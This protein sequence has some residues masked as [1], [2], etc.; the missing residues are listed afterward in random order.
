METLWQDIRF[1]FRILFKS[2]A[3]TLVAALTL[4]LGIGVNTAI[5]SVVNAVLLRPLPGYETGRLVIIWGKTPYSDNDEVTGDAFKEWR[6]QAQSFEQIEAGVFIPCSVTGADAREPAEAVESVIVT[7]GYFSLYRAQAAMGRLFLPGEDSAGRDH[8]VVLDHDYWRRRFSGDPAIVGKTIHLN[9]EEYVVVG[10]TPADFHPLGRGRA[11]FYLPLAFDKYSRTVFWVVARLKAGV[12]FEQA[13][14]EMAVISRR[15]QASDPKNYENFEANPVPILETWVAQIRSVLLLL[16]GGVAVVLLIACANVANLLLARGAARRQEFAI[17]L[18]LGASRF[19]L[20]RQMAVESLLL[21]IGGGGIGLSLA[22]GVVS[23]LGKAKWLS[24]PRLDEISIDWSVL[25][26][27]FLAVI[28]TGLLCSAGPALVITRQDVSR[29]LETGARGFAGSRAQNRA[30]QALIV[31][32]IA[33]TFTLLYVAGLLTQSFARMQRVNLGYDPRNVLTFSI[34]LP[35]TTDPDGRQFIATYDRI[36]ER[37]RRLPGVENVGLTT[38]LPT[39][40]GAGAGGDIR[41]EGRPEPSHNNDANATLRVVSADY[42]RVLHIPLLAG[43]LFDERDTIGRPNVTIINQSVARRFFPDSSPL[44]QRLLDSWLDPNIRGGDDRVI[45]REI[46]GLVGDVKQTSVTDE[47]KMETIAPYS[48]NGLRFTMIA[49]RTTGDPMKLSGA[50]RQ[51]VAQEDKDLPIADVKTMEER[52]ST[53]TAQSRTSVMIFGVFAAL[54]L[55]LAAIGIYGVMA[56]AVT[57]RTREI[58]VRMALGAR[59]WDVRSLI[60]RQGF[61]ITLIGLAGGSCAVFAVAQLL[62]KFLFGVKAADPGALIGV[63]LLLAMAALAACYI[64][65]RRATNVDPMVALRHE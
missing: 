15:L 4:A 13:K 59:G 37:L 55:T 9:R 51:A 52:A 5:F 56:Y 7:P 14:A 44:G 21:A 23:A 29:G 63:A 45:A 11:P 28:I 32:E 46:I 57:Q 49:V 47:G 62:T 36:V 31:A 42:F 16:F 60:L 54:A 8:V 2:P 24:I 40:D 43:R 48:Q 22:V 33:L 17:R 20:A 65:A 19:R 34:T 12:T 6:K 30:R 41:V 25:S 10:I 64:P 1:G 39:G 61:K 35:E 58:G 50:V 3:F 38:C 18:A 53:L 27:N 26:F